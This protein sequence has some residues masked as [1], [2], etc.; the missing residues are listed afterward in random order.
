MVEIIDEG[1]WGHSFFEVYL[2]V[3][4]NFD[5]LRS[6][7]TG[8]FTVCFNEEDKVVLAN[9]E[10]LGGHLENNE[11]IE[12]ALKRECLE[13]GG[14]KLLKWKYFGYYK[15]TQK[16][17]APDTFKK[18]YPKESYLIF[19]L[20]KGKKIMEPYGEDVKGFQVVD[21]KDILNSKR[22]R[23]KLLHEGVKLYPQYIY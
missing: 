12:E 2:D 19:F 20:S 15:I 14:M 6:T 18:M 7:T 5:H 10:P 4:G 22:F 8:V 23:H 21:K 17:T 3:N 11:T 13:E 1:D 16:N 9:N